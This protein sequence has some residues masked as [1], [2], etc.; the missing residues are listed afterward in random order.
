LSLPLSD[1]NDITPWQRHPGY[2]VDKMLAS[3][4][5]GTPSPDKAGQFIQRGTVLVTP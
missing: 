3:G 4:T 5:V 2:F 1:H